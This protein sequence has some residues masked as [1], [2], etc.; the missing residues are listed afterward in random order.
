MGCLAVI[1]MLAL[2][3]AFSVLLGSIAQ[4]LLLQ[5]GVHASLFVCVIAVW[6]I[7]MITGGV[8]YNK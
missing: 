1:F 2:W 7:G 5:F 6:F 4:W 3:A 8:R